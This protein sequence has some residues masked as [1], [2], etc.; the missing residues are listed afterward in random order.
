MD[1]YTPPSTTA[2]DIPGQ[3]IRRPSSVRIAGWFFWL[4]GIGI[5]ALQVKFVGTELADL[6]S[7]GLLCFC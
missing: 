2:I 6:S 4:F 7:V 5:L 3:R 1:P